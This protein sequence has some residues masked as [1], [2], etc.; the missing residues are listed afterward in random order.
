MQAQSGAALLRPM[1]ADSLTRRIAPVARPAGGN[2]PTAQPP[3]ANPPAMAAAAPARCAAARSPY[4]K[5]AT[6]PAAQRGPAPAPDSATP[7]HGA[8]P[9]AAAVTPS[10]AEPLA[11]DPLDGL[12]LLAPDLFTAGPDAEWPDETCEDAVP[13]ASMPMPVCVPLYDLSAP[14][15]TRR[16]WPWALLGSMALLAACAF[17]AWR[18]GLLATLF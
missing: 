15:P 17:G 5:P 12:E 16:R 8:Q 13:S 2:P 9:E 14:A 4:L 6:L 1:R 10:P 11:A 7:L 3:S 18:L